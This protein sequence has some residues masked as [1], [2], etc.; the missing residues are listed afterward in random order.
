MA[1]L[2]SSRQV[3]RRLQRSFER[4]N[5]DRLSLP[6][7]PFWEKRFNASLAAEAGCEGW[8]GEEGNDLTP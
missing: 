7:L 4:R 2:K 1:L 8:I 3:Q 6:S 5:S